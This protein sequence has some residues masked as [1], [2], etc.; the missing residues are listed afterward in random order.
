MTTDSRHSRY[1]L[2]PYQLTDL[3]AVLNVFIGAVREVAARDYTPPQI[4]AWV[5]VDRH[6]FGQRCLNPVTW[7]AVSGHTLVGFTHLEPQ[8]HLDMLF[9]HPAW[10]GRGIATRLLACAERAA[11]TGG[12]TQLFTEASITARPFFARRGFQLLEQQQVV[13]HGQSLTNF[14]MVKA[15]NVSR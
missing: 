7:V 15:I 6:A 4:N 10:Q 3:D 11:A 2:R 14:R 5:Q 13:R 12:A 9:V 8:N 1:T